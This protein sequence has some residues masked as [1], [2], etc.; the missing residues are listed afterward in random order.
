M[1]IKKQK[2]EKTKKEKAKQTKE[3]KWERHQQ[4]KGNHQ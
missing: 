4:V 3:I 1:L 2:K